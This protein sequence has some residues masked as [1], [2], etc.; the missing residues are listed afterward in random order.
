MAGDYLMQQISD[1]TRMLAESLFVSRTT[2]PDAVFDIYG[3]FSG[4]NFLSH[5]LKQMVTNGEV[6]EAENMLFEELDKDAST[7]MLKIGLEFYQDLET[8]SDA[9]LASM[10][11]S[12]EDILKGLERLQTYYPKQK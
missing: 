2:E 11:Y 6:L 4:T 5:M 8:R 1:M 3:N 7:D 10:R 9:S 12:R